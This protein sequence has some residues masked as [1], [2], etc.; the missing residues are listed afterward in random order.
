MRQAVH[1]VALVAA[2]CLCSVLVAVGTAVPAGASSS[3]PLNGRG[4]DVS[5]APLNPAFLSSLVS[6]P[7]GEQSRRTSAPP[8]AT[9]PVRQDF[10]YATGMQMPSMRDFGP[11]PATYD[12]RTFGRV[13]SVKNQNPR[14]TCWAFASCGSLE[15][16][17]L[18]GE[19]WDFSEDNMVLQ[20]GFDTGGDPYDHGG[21]RRHVHRLPGPLG[22][23]CDRKPGRVQ[24]RLTPPGLTPSKH[25]QEV[26]LIP[27]RGSALD[28]DNI[29]NAVMQ[30]GGAYVSMGW[31]D[32]AYNATTKSYYYSGSSGTNHGVL[33]VG[34]N[35]NYAAANFVT[36]PPGNGAVHRQEQLG[37][38]VGEQRLLL[39]LLLRHS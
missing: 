7:I 6:P 2:L 20:S 4:L 29:K 1:H 23:P 26:D 33:I 21:N 28:N 24:R 16:C 18:P 9:Y 36:A 30:Y 31:Y 13:T 11:L 19:T 8:W 12:L 35:D 3:T 34:W 5:A 22:R 32:S 10:S 14:G 15:S 17:L 27:A 39:R 25:V 38:G 37:Y